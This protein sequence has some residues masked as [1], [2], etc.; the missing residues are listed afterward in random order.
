MHGGLQGCLLISE[1]H[2]PTE[3]VG[4]NVLDSRPRNLPEEELELEF[5]SKG[6]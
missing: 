5:A 6:K 3:A 2:F 4:T 1:F